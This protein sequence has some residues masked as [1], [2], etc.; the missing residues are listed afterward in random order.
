MNIWQNEEDK[1]ILQF[2]DKINFSRMRRVVIKVT[3]YTSKTNRE[4]TMKKKQIKSKRNKP[5][6][7][8][9]KNNKQELF[10]SFRK[11]NKKENILEII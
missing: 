2:D 1:N 8:I 10:Q 11:Q 7:K 9:N 3:L 5:K 4:K 6:N